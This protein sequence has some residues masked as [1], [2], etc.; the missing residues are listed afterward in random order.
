MLTWAGI[1]VL[2]LLVIAVVG[3]VLWTR[4]GPDPTANAIAAAEQADTITDGWLAFEPTTD[5]S[6]GVVLYPGARIDN[7]AYAPVADAL[8]ER[9]GA[10]VAVLDAQLDI[11][12]LDTGAAADV[13][14]TYPDIDHW[15]VGGH[16]LGGVAAAR[17]AADNDDVDGLL[18]WGSYPSG[19]AIPDDVAVTSITGSR[20]G[21]LDR[22]AYREARSLLPTTTEH[23]ELEGVNHAQ[24]GDYGDQ[25][26]DGTA[27]VEPA[28]AQRM[29]VDASTGV[30][31]AVAP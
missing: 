6:V 29:I 19:R 12:L 5:P 3:G 2:A 25:S 27:T 10:L 20:D 14:A 17:F 31:E 21:V 22:D 23:V 24:F 15:V 26:G 1:A 4:A 16:S 8:A 28:D 18:L 7:A 13:I 30:V 11:A 9:T